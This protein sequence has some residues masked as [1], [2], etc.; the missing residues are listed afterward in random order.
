MRLRFPPTLGSL[1]AAASD[2]GHR[3]AFSNVLFDGTKGGQ[4]RA[5]ATDGKLLVT[6]AGVEPDAPCPGVVPHERPDG[7]S[8]TAL[9]PA[10]DLKEVCDLVARQKLRNPSVDLFAGDHDAL[11]V[12]Q[13]ISRHVMLGDGRFPDWKQVIPGKPP[14]VRVRLIVKNLERILQVFK[15]LGHEVV[16]LGVYDNNTPVTFNAATP[17]QMADALLMTVSEPK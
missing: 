16:T 10:R 7:A 14:A 17:E 3:Q 15:K 5:T 8:K 6:V 2:G 1:A 11:L 4:Y 9:L 12:S 13:G